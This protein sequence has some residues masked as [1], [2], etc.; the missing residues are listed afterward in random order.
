VSEL[1]PE[2]MCKL[3]LPFRLF[4]LFLF[5]ILLFSRV[6]HFNSPAA[7]GQVQLPGSTRVNCLRIPAAVLWYRGL[8][9][10]GIEHSS[11]NSSRDRD[12]DYYRIALTITSSLGSMITT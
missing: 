6:P 7:Y 9:P 8:L 4:F 11:S 10:E 3:Q 12:H 5:H 1:V 2:L